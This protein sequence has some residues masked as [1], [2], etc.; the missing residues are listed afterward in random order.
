[1]GALG[2]GTARAAVTAVGKGTEILTGL[3]LLSGRDTDAPQ[4]PAVATV[5]KDDPS[6]NGGFALGIAA[7]TRGDLV[8]DRPYFTGNPSVPWMA[9]RVRRNSEMA[10]YTQVGNEPNLA[11][12]GWDG[13]AGVYQAFYYAVATDRTLYAPP[14]LGVPGWEQWIGTARRYAV[15]AY[16]SA[17]QMRAVVQHYLDHTAGELYLTELNPG[18]GNL[19]NLTAWALTELRSFLT[20][21]AG[22]PRIKFATYFAWRWDQS[23][24]LPSSIDAAECPVLVAVLR[25]AP[26]Q[27]PEEQRMPKWTVGAGVAAE[28]A[29]Q[30]DVPLSSERYVG[31]WFSLAVGAKGLYVYSKEANKTVFLPAG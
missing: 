15:H 12:E 19:F 31:E 16:G 29:R 1:M 6:D 4:L 9:A 28:M 27:P 11:S 14:T 2:A 23:P 20:W 25:D 22:Q 21:C 17:G 30:G 10:M 3:V 8:V 13:G 24:T 26:T 18:A 7:A 5:S